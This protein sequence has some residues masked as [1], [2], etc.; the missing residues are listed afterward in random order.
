MRR[1]GFRADVVQMIEARSSCQCEV[2][3]SG[4]ELVMATIHHRRPRGAGGSRREDTNAACNGL[5]ICTHCHHKVETQRAWARERG[6]IVSQWGDPNDVAVHWRSRIDSNG[7]N[8]FV[9][10][11]NQ[12]GMIDEQVTR[13]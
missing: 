2:M 4:C 8:V 7:R 10:L 13:F 5:A 11:D 6:F 1:T 3:A 12:G 9:F